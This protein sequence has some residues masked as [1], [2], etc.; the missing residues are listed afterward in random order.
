MATASEAPTVAEA[1]RRTVADAPDRVAVRTLDDAVSLTWGELAR[2]VDALAGGVARLGVVR[3]DTVALMIGNR[4][5]CHLVDLAVTTLGATPF[6]L[7]PTLTPEQIAYVVGDAGARI[8]IAEAA[9][10]PSLLA[11]RRDLPELA[12]LVVLDGE[13]PDANAPGGVE[14]RSE[15]GRVAQGDG[16]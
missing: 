1:F 3:G 11:A 14:G 5:E 6:S 16:R 15:A 8:A 2:R 7:Y 9:L 10:L 13:A 12:R 4:P